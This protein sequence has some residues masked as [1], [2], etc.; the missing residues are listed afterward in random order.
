MHA[1]PSILALAVALIVMACTS[2][3]A[4]STPP[5]SAHPSPVATASPTPTPTDRPA[6]PTASPAAACVETTL[7]SL[8]EAQRIGQLFLV[9]L[10]DDRFDSAARQAIVDHHLGSWWFTRTTDVGVDGLRAVADAVQAESTEAA[11]GKPKTLFKEEADGPVPVIDRFVKGTA[12]G[13]ALRRWLEQTGT[14]TTVSGV[15]LM[16]A[17]SAVV[18][19]FVV[20][21][22]VR[23]MWG[24]IAGGVLGFA[25]PFMIL[26]VKRN[27]R[28]HKFEEEFP[29]EILEHVNFERGFIEPHTVVDL[30]VGKEFPIN[31]HLTVRGQF[32]VENVTDTD[33][34][35]TFESVFSGTTVGRPRSY[36]GSLS[37]DF[38]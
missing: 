27:K 36:T 15:L 10:E 4:T 28:L 8:T 30:S 21:M 13:T 11:E 16:G 18:F 26:N 20:A 19:G 22:A 2:T 37:F 29:E 9:G 35:F 3:A 38:K 23:G 12:Q 6:S 5:P 25:V 34:L 1:R 24:F 32:N 31:E 7:A 17:A 14:R 33:Y